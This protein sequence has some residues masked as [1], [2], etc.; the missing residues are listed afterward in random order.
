MRIMR[1]LAVGLLTA[2]VLMLGFCLPSISFFLW[3]RSSAGQVVTED[4]QLRTVDREPLNICNM[5]HMAYVTDKKAI[6]S[7]GKYLTPSS[8]FERAKAALEPIGEMEFFDIEWEDCTLQDYSIVFCISGEDLSKRMTLWTLTI[9]TPQGAVMRVSL[10]DRTGTVL[11]FSYS[12][13]DRPLHTSPIPPTESQILGKALTELFARYWGVSIGGTTVVSD[14]GGY[15]LSVTDET[16]G[17][18]AEVPYFLEQSGVRVN[19]AG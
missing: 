4:L 12:D 18:K 2:A 16:S 3:D 10:E 1:R 17:L 9:T 11:G 14:S 8:A 15:L 6:L 13:P 19:I 7:R 5:L